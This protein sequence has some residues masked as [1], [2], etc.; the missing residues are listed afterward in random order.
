[1]FGAFTNIADSTTYQDIYELV[2]HR[3]EHYY[4]Q[5]VLY[6]EKLLHSRIFTFKHRILERY[7]QYVLDALQVVMMGVPF[8]IEK[9]GFPLPIP[10]KDIERR[11]ATIE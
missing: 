6:Q 5:V 7:L 8:E 1:L 11:T 10:L 9:A 2:M 3:L 4:Q